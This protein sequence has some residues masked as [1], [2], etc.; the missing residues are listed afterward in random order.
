M[1]VSR[2]N[3]GKF[4]QRLESEICQMFN[5]PHVVA[6]N[7]ATSGLH[8]ALAAIGVGFGDRVLVPAITMTATASAVYM[9]G[10]TPV[11]VDVNPL[12]GLSEDLHYH[13]ANDFAESEWG[14]K[15][16][17]AMVVHLFGDVANVPRIVDAIP[18]MP[19]VEDCAQAP[20]A[21]DPQ[22]RFVGTRTRCGVFSL[23][24]HKVITCGEGG[25]CCTPIPEIAD[26]LKLIRNHGENY[27]PDI[28]GY[29][30]RMTELEA[31]VALDEVSHLH[32]RQAKR[33][34]WS[35]YLSDQLESQDMYQPMKVNHP[36]YMYM[37]IDNSL[38]QSGVPPA[39]R[40]GYSTPLCCI[41]Y[42]EKRNEFG[43]LPGAHKFNTQVLVTDPPET[44]EQADKLAEGV[45]ECAKSCSI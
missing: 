10:A 25:L 12:T 31:A 14:S 38:D 7:S 28:L 23:N 11:F 45:L 16:A 20:G 27:D 32:E 39:F 6:V 43:H 3:G 29:N 21:V 18:G 9:C 5:V 44:Q 36:P 35:R 15:P 19:I 2:P 22:G 24:Q 1:R 17:V 34:K 26:K 13:E 4:L 37:L 30:Y 33:L 40:R 41:P 42:F 8:A